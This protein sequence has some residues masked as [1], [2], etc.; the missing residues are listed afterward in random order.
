MICMC[1]VVVQCGGRK[2]GM[3]GSVQTD[4]NVLQP[5]AFEADSAYAYVRKQVEFGPRVPNSQA[6]ELCGDYLVAM[7]RGFGA[8]VQEQKTDIKA[9]DGRLLQCRNIMASYNVNQKDRVLLLAHWDSRP[10]ADNDPDPD[11]RFHPVDGANDGASGVGVLLEIA[12]QLG[13]HQPH[14]GIDILLTDLEDYGRTGGNDEDSWCLGTQYW[15]KNAVAQGYK[16]RYGILL[17]MVGAPNAVFPHEG[18]SLQYASAVVQKVWS[19]GQ[20]LG[21]GQYFRNARLGMITDDHVVVNRMTGI[22][23]IDIIHFDE[24]GFGSY[25]HTSDDG[26]Q[27]VSV[28]T[29]RAVG[30]TVLKVIRE[31]QVTGM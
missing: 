31:E 2:D 28:S 20:I 11:D 26:M 9:W 1:L 5:P 16:A 10:W 7:L 21:Y 30:E 19:A 6:H 12:R 23:A 25:W 13:M 17:D 4:G 29:L 27:N 18:F 15:A 8:E 3:L 14:I 22:P 24:Q